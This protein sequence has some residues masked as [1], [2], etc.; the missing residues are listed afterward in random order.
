MD[1]AYDRLIPDY[2]EYRARKITR[3]ESR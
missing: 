2:D 3:L 1:G